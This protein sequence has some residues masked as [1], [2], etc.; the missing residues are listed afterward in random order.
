M[1]GPED[2]HYT[3]EY[4]EHFKILPA[5]NDWYMDPKRIKDGKPVKEG[6]QYASDNNS[7]WMTE[8]DL[9]EFVEKGK[10]SFLK[11]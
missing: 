6:F 3:Y 9:I 8:Q 7:D 11:I 5:I 2:A 1:V 4:P 10:Q